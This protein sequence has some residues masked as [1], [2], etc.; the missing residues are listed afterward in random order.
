MSAPRLTHLEQVTGGVRPAYVPQ[1]HGCG[2]V[3]IGVGAFHRA[4]QAVMTDDALGQGGGDWRIV[5]VSLRSKQIAEDLNHQNGLFTVIERDGTGAKARVIG[6]VAHVIAADPAETLAALC[7][8]AIRIVTLTV[9]ENGYGIDRASRMPDRTVPTVA[10]DIANPDAPSGVLGLLVAAIARRRA[11]GHV[12]FAVLSCDN[13]PENGALLRDG[14]AGFARATGRAEL[15]DWIVANVAFPCSMVD[16]IT[17]AATP[18]TV[19][20]AATLTGCTDLAAIETEPFSHWV[21]EDQFPNGRPAWEAGGAIFV[22]DVA[23]YEKMKLTMLNGTHSMLAYAG[24]LTEKPFV[25]DVMADRDLSVLVRRHM[26][27]AAGV[28]GT[29]AG[30]DRNDYAA[31]LIARFSNPAIAHETRQIAMDGSQKLPQRI[32][33]PAVIALDRGQNVRPF[34][35]AA[36]MW[37]R[38]CL[39]QKDDGTSYPIVDPRADEIAAA[40]AGCARGADDISTA[41]HGLP[42]FIPSR[43]AL[44]DQWRSQVS[45]CLGVIL[46]QGC[47]SALTQEAESSAEDQTGFREAQYS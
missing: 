10:A 44:D 27:A 34:A 26:M 2:I 20:T 32:F 45:E 18:D 46:E 11:A 21:I 6:S 31:A 35:F 22:R 43:L 30:V 7:D 1:D 37:M 12:A 23:P 13:L 47:Q 24:F 33:R 8:P 15:A 17:P 19:Q 25:R 9:T 28:L 14:V 42:N 5:G 41:L 38:F 40:L 4:H 29:L 39:A 36:A 16:R 3:H